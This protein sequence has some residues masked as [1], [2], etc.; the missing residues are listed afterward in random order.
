[1]MI[2]WWWW[3]LVDYVICRLWLCEI[4]DFASYIGQCGFKDWARTRER[5]NMKSSLF[6]YHILCPRGL[7]Y[8][9]L[10][11]LILSFT[12]LRLRRSL[13]AAFGRSSFFFS[14]VPDISRKCA[15][16]EPLVPRVLVPFPNLVLSSHSC[17]YWILPVSPFDLPARAVIL[18]DVLLWTWLYRN[19]D[20][21]QIY[22]LCHAYLGSVQFAGRPFCRIHPW[23]SSKESLFPEPWNSWSSISLRRRIQGFHSTPQTT[24]HH[25]MPR[26][27]QCRFNGRARKDFRYFE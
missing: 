8:T 11:S 18:W 2:T 13:P 9:P 6:P 12:H 15:A 7:Y 4:V 22:F 3:W 1:M 19:L 5:I 10:M 16:R 25:P 21:K 26:H 23:F 27:R 14:A 20:Y 24:Q 17:L